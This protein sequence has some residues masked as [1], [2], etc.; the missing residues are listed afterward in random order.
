MQ[1]K[2]IA[3]AVATLAAGSA[4]A[5]SNVT[6]SGYLSSGF[7]STKISGGAT[8][9]IRATNGTETGVI[10]SRLSRIRF[11]GSED[12]G[13]GLKAIFQ[14]ESRFMSDTADATASLGAMGVGDT[15]VGLAGN[16]GQVRMG[17][18]DTYY[19]DGVLTELIAGT[20]FQSHATLSLLSQVDGFG[21][22]GTAGRWNNLIRYDSPRVSGFQGSVAYSSNRAAEDGVANNDGDD[23]SSWYAS[24]NY[25]AG[26]I[27]AGVSAM[28]HRTE[29]VTDNKSSGWR[30]YGSYTF[31]MGV[32][33]GLN[34]DHG[35]FGTGADTWRKRNAWFLPVS[36]KFGKNT[37]AGTYGRAGKTKTNAGTV[38]SS[39]ATFYNLSYNYELSKR[40]NIGANYTVLKNKDGSAYDLLLGGVVRGLG[41][42]QATGSGQDVRQ[43]A[44]SVVHAF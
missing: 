3:L 20:T 28:Q 14:V 44:V 6:I 36:Y 25:F 7:A 23:G 32:K 31:P 11:A 38:N 30:V 5:Q 8:P 18:I 12:L 9:A 21:Y 22:H 29:G 10:D 13:N 1:K 33:V 19:A 27:Y 37:V 17:R 15:F 2:L 34:Y 24:A 40:T 41:Q 26:P 35:R 43:I 42:V 39:G 16:W 4:F